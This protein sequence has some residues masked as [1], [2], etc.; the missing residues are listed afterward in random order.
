VNVRNGDA[1]AR[2]VRAEARGKQ[3]R[4]L[5]DIAAADAAF[6]VWG[7]TPEEMCIAAADALLAVMVENPEEVAAQRTVDL[8]FE[9]E[10][11]EMLLYRLL[12]ELV[13]LKDARKL[14]LRIADLHIT[15]RRGMFRMEGDAYGEEIDPRKHRMI[16][17]V[18]AVT[19]HRFKVEE[20]EGKWTATVVVDV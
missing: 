16:V 1:P 2:P 15:A 14:L 17:D 10:S 19:F 12:E 8:H 5:D 9:S 7:N 3:Y 13:F 20:R 11:L 6:E 18:K 4:F